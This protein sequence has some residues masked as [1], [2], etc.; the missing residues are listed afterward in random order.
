MTL[1]ASVG[2]AARP[3]FLYSPTMG[4]GKNQG[5]ENRHGLRQGLPPGYRNALAPHRAEGALTAFQTPCDC[6]VRYP[7]V[8][9][10]DAIAARAAHALPALCDHGTGHILT[11]EPDG[12]HIRISGGPDAVAEIYIAIPWPQQVLRFPGGYPDGHACKRAPSTEALRSYF[13]NLKNP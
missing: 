3:L 13:A 8:L 9:V 6:T 12:A 11:T 1:I 5:E 10:E 4:N 2:Q 7:T